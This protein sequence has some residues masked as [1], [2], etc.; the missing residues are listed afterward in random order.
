LWCCNTSLVV[1][2]IHSM[3]KVIPDEGC[4]C[5]ARRVMAARGGAL[6]LHSS[7]L[8]LKSLIREGSVSASK[9]LCQIS[10]MDPSHT[11]C[12]PA[13]GH[14]SM[15]A[16]V[17]LGY[18]QHGHS[19]VFLCLLWIIQL[20]I[21]QKPVTNFT[22]HQCMFII[23]DFSTFSTVVQLTWCMSMPWKRFLADQ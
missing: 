2:S 10:K 16:V 5:H 6:C 17:S 11:I 15:Y 4:L 9:R 21:A 18:P 13:S 12:E 14:W 1:V 8:A 20:P 19:A 23:C 7:S 22:V 3:N